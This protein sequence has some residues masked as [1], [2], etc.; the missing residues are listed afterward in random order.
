MQNP[1]K[2][3]LTLNGPARLVIEAASVATFVDP[4]VTATDPEV[5]ARLWLCGRAREW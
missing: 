1:S 2:P 4:G 5:R 3:V